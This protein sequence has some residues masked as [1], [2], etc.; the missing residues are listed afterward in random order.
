MFLPIQSKFLLDA[1]YQSGIGGMAMLLTIV[2]LILS[3]SLVL[4]LPILRWCVTGIERG[5]LKNAWYITII[6]SAQVFALATI[7]FTTFLQLS[8]EQSILTLLS[9]LAILALL[10]VGYNIFIKWLTSLSY[11]KDVNKEMV[12]KRGE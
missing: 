4:T 7:F 2:G 6:I 12:I 10:L 11:N 1:E 8:I 5:I 9:R 3:V